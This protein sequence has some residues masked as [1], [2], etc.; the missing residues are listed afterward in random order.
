MAESLLVKVPPVQPE[1]AEAETDWPTWGILERVKDTEPV[2]VGQVLPPQ[3][4]LFVHESVQAV[5]LL[6]VDWQV[7][8]EQA[9]WVPE[10]AG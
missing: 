4:T 8:P 2:A 1:G 9:L 7:V 3:E 10:T 5:A 6:A